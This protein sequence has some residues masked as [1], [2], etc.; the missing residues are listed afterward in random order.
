MREIRTLLLIWAASGLLAAVVAQGPTRSTTQTGDMT[1][2]EIQQLV[3]AYAL[4]QA[5]EI[6]EL[7]D[8]QYARFATQLKDLQ[9]LRR[10]GQRERGA[11]MQGLARL[12]RQRPAPDDALVRDR[13][14]ALEAHDARVATA[15]GRAYEAIDQVLTLVQRARFRVFEEQME[16]RRL[17]LL[18][19]GQRGGSADPSRQPPSRERRN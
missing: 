15:L 11:L 16:R 4:V 8:A 2:T 1:P 13:L 18:Q 19:Q 3:D 5:Q 9:A 6:L 14:D 17:Q 12:A 10:Q 7:S